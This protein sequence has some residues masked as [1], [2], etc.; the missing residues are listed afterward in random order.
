MVVS[1]R[2]E[3]T[4]SDNIAIAD[5]IGAATDDEMDNYMADCQLNVHGNQSLPFEMVHKHGI[6]GNS[7]ADILNGYLEKSDLREGSSELVSL[8][9][10]NF[11]SGSTV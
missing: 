5:E 3:G 10:I 4:S 7:M 2:N 8:F 6:R 9:S 1:D 11:S